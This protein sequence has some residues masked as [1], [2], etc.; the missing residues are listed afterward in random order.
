M[1]RNCGECAVCCYLC[2]IR[3]IKK[4][5]HIFCF[6]QL[7]ELVEH[8]CMIFDDRPE[9]CKNFLCAWIRNFGSENDRPDKNGVMITVS[10]FNNGIWIFII[11]IKQDAVLTTAKDMIIEIVEQYDIPAIVSDYKS[12]P[13]NDTGDYTIVK[14][15]LLNRCKSMTGDLINYLDLD[16]KIGLY[17]L[18]K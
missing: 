9:D 4:P 18:R 8:R 2:E 1:S 11:E 7:K 12:R 13:P 17:K 5:P 10:K 15:S 14:E 3:E 16:E 6:Y